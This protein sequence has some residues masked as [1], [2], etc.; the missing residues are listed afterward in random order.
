MFVA[1]DSVQTL[2]DVCLMHC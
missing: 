1:L 2:F